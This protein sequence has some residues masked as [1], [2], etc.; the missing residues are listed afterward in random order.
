ML[1]NIMVVLMA[2]MLTII[3]FQITIFIELK[4]KYN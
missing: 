3:A 4:K 2:V 1:E